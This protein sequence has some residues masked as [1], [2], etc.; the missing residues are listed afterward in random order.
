MSAEPSTQASAGTSTS[1]ATVPGAPTPS[2]ATFAITDPLPTGT[3]L[4]EASA[5]T[6]KT[7]TIAAL[8]TRYV[9]EGEATLPEMLV[10]TFGR[11]ASQ[12]LRARVREALVAAERLLLHPPRRADGTPDLSGL[13]DL[14]RL[15]LD[16]P[17]EERT[18]RLARLREA[19]TGF[20]AATIAT[21][22][23]FCQLVL[24]SLGVAGDTDA[25]A[26]LVEDLDDL[27]V[28]VV[29]DTYLRGFAGSAEPP[30]F[31][32]GEALRIARKAVD[33]SHAEL[34]PTDAERGSPADRRARFGQAV[35]AE[36]DRRKR[37]L[38]VLHYQD[39]LTQLAQALEAPAGAVSPARERMRRRWR[40]VLV[41]EFQDT[42]PVQWQ[43]L[44][45]A[46]TGHAT[47]VLIGDPKQAIYAFRGGDVVT[48]LKAAAT[49]GTTMTLG[50]NHRSDAP[51]VDSLQ[52]LLQGAALGD[53][54]ICVHP[55]IA[56][57]EGSRLDAAPSPQPLRLRVVPRARLG[58]KGTRT[59]TV[60]RV[61]EVLARDAA[62]DIATLVASDATWCGRPLRPNQVAV[63]AHKGKDLAL[64]QREL[65]EVGLPSVVAGGGSVFH[66]LA[67][68]EWLTLLEALA[69]PHRS[70]RTRATA[71]TSLV[72]YTPV[73]LDSGG[74][75]LSDALAT[76]LR[77]LA[78]VCERRGVAAVLE[79]AIIHGLPERVLGTVA[80]ERHLTDLRHVGQLLHEAGTGQQGGM[81]L[82]GLTD[83]LRAQMAEDAPPGASARTR[84]L[85]S[86]ASAVQ[87]VTIHGS[88]GLQYPVVYLPFLADRWVPKQPDI[89]LFHSPPPERVRTL[90]VGGPGAPHWAESVRAHQHEDAGESLR[91]L[92]VALTRAQSQVVAWW[93]PG[94]NTPASAW[95][96]MLLGRGPGEATVPDAFRLPSDEDVVRT[97]A[98][99]S[100][101]SGKQPRPGAHIE[102]VED[103]TPP[104]VQVPAPTT[105]LAVR[106]FARTVDTAWRRTSY[107]ALSSP[108]EAVAAASGAAAD[109]PGGVGSE[110]EVVPRE[111]EPDAPEPL[112][113]DTLPGLGLP[114]LEVPSPMADLPV[115]ATFGSLVH[116][117]LEHAD[118]QAPDLHAELAEQVRE[119]L[120]R[121]PVDLGEG[122]TERLAGALV[123][124][125]ETPLGPLAKGATLRQVG[126]ADRLSELD[127]ELPLAGGDDTGY[128][129][130]AV[131][132]GDLR[133][134]LLT[135]LPEGD[136]VRGWA[137]ALARPELGE[138][139]LRG[140]LTGSVDAVLRTGGRYLVVDYKTNWLGAP[141]QPLTAAAY[142]PEALAQAM[143]HSSYPLQALLYAVVAH[144]F[145]RWRLRGYDPAR[146][147]GGVLYLYLRG[148]CGPDTPVVDGHPCGVFS[149]RPPVALVQ[150]VSDL[151]DGRRA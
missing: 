147:L 81:G 22:H 33:D 31:S 110:P 143:G 100:C 90:D 52:A 144:R 69:A 75:E 79:H 32:R 89:P 101:G 53:P 51:L 21:T 9:A 106:R 83:W 58:V 99:W 4:L 46:F 137:E 134:L 77:D 6:G 67:A 73:D 146:H 136:P 92:Y 72:G 102:F 36:L 132:L 128:P 7:W 30:A 55:V 12:E 119:Q 85:D 116:A 16:A 148:M 18:R 59:A 26:T 121:W 76:R 15:L 44:D 43:V 56:R 118:P 122:G 1:T 62:C 107:T 37:R 74:E 42:D 125:C 49:A 71:L 141:E 86:D 123:A 93:A 20:D 130:E 111:D 103:A 54:G 17:E 41:D 80:G 87:L 65:A 91:L 3:T 60:G 11:A 63:L 94:N 114:G 50:T 127:F 149:W 115:G 82:L 14:Q 108:A 131:T 39:L 133:P 70:T 64:M 61:R 97:L 129:A 19:L 47:M 27:L 13:D 96:R 145:L 38:G 68:T 48:Y 135:Q 109:S 28:E 105:E 150:A 151:L 78:V 95:H 124:A 104:Q 98:R 84:R 88:K 5:G 66:T 25:G 45:R 57:H 112:E 126:T 113:D 10:V 40:V 34:A 29:D 117:V 2:P 35:R 8:V 120:L 142:R 23:Q 140:Y 138:Q 139:P 24:R